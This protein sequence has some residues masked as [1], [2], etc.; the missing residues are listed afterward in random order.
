MSDLRAEMMDI[1]D[2]YNPSPSLTYLARV[3]DFFQTKKDSLDIPDMTILCAEVERC[4]VYANTDRIDTITIFRNGKEQTIDRNVPGLDISKESVF[5]NP[6]NHLEEMKEERD[7]LAREAEAQKVQ[8]ERKMPVVR[9]P[10]P[11]PV[12]MA[13]APV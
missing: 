11:A 8:E 5:P 1:L 12:P 4:R 7:R 9:D 3:L 2:P 6:Y 10:I 13:A